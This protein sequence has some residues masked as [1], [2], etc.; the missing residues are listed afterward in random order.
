MSVVPTAQHTKQQKQ[1]NNQTRAPF[2]TDALF[3]TYTKSVFGAV[4]LRSKYLSVS[5]FG[6]KN[7]TA[8]RA[9]F[10]A[11]IKPSTTNLKGNK[12]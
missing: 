9:Y 10:C 12:P 8:T 6:Y 3:G 4:R 11:T 1:A 7:E 2:S 5:C